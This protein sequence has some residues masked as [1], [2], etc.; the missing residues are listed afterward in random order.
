MTMGAPQFDVVQF[1]LLAE[2]TVETAIEAL[3]FSAVR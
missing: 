1:R 2:Y 3:S